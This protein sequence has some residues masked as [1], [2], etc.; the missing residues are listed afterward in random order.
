MV[1]RRQAHYVV[2]DGRGRCDDQIVTVA[3]VL[4]HI[5]ETDRAA[6]AGPI[7]DGDRYIDQLLLLQDALNYARRAV[8]TAARTGWRHNLHTA[9][10][11]PFCRMATRNRD[12]GRR[13][14]GHCL[15]RKEFDSAHRALIRLADARR[16]IAS[17]PADPGQPLYS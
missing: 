17:P 4:I 12:Q 11:F 7:D 6:A 2:A 1:I 10:R 9:F 13:D 5:I 8:S 16:N 15:L 3:R 14:A